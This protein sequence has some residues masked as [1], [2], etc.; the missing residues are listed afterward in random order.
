M[1]DLASILEQ[2]YIDP[3]RTVLVVDDEFISLDKMI[4]I[5]MYTHTHDDISDIQYHMNI[6]YPNG[7]DL[8][9]SRELIK[10]F[11][12]PGRNWLCDIHDGQDI[13]D[14]ITDHLHQSDLLILD[15]NLTG[16]HDDGTKSLELIN[17]ISHNDHFNLVVV[18]TKNNIENTFHEILFNLTT[19]SEYFESLSIV[20][21]DL[22][23]SLWESQDDNF[24][25][26]ITTLFEG[27][28][29]IEILSL[30]NDDIKYDKLSYYNE[31]LDLFNDMPDNVGFTIK[32][33]VDIGSKKQ[34]DLIKHQLV[35]VNGLTCDADISS[36]VNWIKNNRLFITVIDKK[37]VEPVLLPEYL[38]K[39]LLSWNPKPHRLLMSKIRAELDNNGALFEDA[40][41]SNNYVHAGWLKDFIEVTEE[42]SK[43]V[44]QQTVS[45]AVELMSESMMQSLE[46]F[47]SALREELKGSP[48]K[49]VIS[50]YHGVNID[51]RHDK[52]EICKHLNAH[53][54]SQL[55]SGNQLSTGHIVEVNEE[56]FI[57]L[58]PACDLVPTQKSDWKK[59][60]GTLMPFKLV[61]LWNCSDRFKPKGKT[62]SEEKLL[63]NLNSNENVVI[64]EDGKIKGYSILK[65][66]GA[67][68]QWEQ[69]FC[70]ELGKII[71]EDD[72]PFIVFTKIVHSG[73][74]SNIVGNRV[75]KAKIVS[76]LRY[77]YAINLLQKF[78]SSQSR[79]GLD[80]LQYRA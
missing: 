76:Q 60:L 40:I 54:C 66:D 26:K 3:I 43:W 16:D 49:D 68:P 33:F 9:R 41:L 19:P 39:A 46:K 56:K 4:E 45:Q 15:Y 37:S 5:S 32:E 8:A 13:S 53:R 77:E 28:R 67:N 61:R 42:K 20:K 74:L 47:S 21:Y 11:R 6:E 63:S 18:Y 30:T 69:A 62:S 65:A 59:E 72:K 23:L 50:N 27:T 70:H 7:L 71:W 55:V 10:A 25:E 24:E 78:G 1:S 48:V 64:N 57:C 2:V 44:T 17:K 31:I 35:G 12:A 80:F 22:K 73:G 52:L 38:G 75:V 36:N 58:T 14:T 34:Y 51:D 29:L 79:V